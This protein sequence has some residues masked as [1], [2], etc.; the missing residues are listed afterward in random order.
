MDPITSTG[1]LALSIV[2][3][4]FA[5]LISIVVGLFFA[6]EGYTLGIVSIGVV[7]GLITG[8]L[9]YNLIF[10][11]LQSLTLFLILAIAGA[12]I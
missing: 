11:S 7:T 8:V 6:Y 9:L 12:I 2:S 4:L 3:I 5:V 10:Y 1:S